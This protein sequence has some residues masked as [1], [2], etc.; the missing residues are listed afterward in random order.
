LVEVLFITNLV[1]FPFQKVCGNCYVIDVI[2]CSTSHV[3]YNA[4]HSKSKV[5]KS[6]FL[7]GSIATNDGP[8]LLSIEGKWLETIV[9]MAKFGFLNLACP[10]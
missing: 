2:I 5:H 8:I 7:Q 10:K 4:R 9:H 3:D 1:A 6:S